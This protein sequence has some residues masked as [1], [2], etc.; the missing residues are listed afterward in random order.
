MQ[1]DETL[2]KDVVKKVEG[3]ISCDCEVVKTTKRLLLEEKSLEVRTCAG[4]EGV[5]KDCGWA[6]ISIYTNGGYL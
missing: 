2:N 3:L 4:S 6:Q 1:L 5:G